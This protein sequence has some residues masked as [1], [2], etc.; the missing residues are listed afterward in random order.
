MTSLHPEIK[1]KAIQRSKIKFKHTDLSNEFIKQMVKLSLR[2]TARVISE[3]GSVPKDDQLFSNI[4]S[5]NKDELAAVD[6]EP[7]SASNVIKNKID[8]PSLPHVFGQITEIMSDL[9]SSASDFAEIIS[10]DPALSARMLKIVNSAFY[11]FRSRVDTISRAVAIIGTN[12][13][14]SLSLSMSVLKIF[15]N[16]PDHFVDMQ[17]FWQ[18]C[19]ACG[20]IAKIIATHQGFLNTERF[21]VAGLLHDIG[22][23]VLYKYLPNETKRALVQAGLN[24]DLLFKSESRVLG[25]NHSR[26]G[27]MLMKKW[28]LPPE[29]DH[30][31]RF[32]H[33]PE[34][35]SFF[36][37]TAIIHVS[38]ILTNAFDFGTSGERFVPPLSKEVWDVLKL[39][40]GLI[41]KIVDQTN[42]QIVEV[43]QILTS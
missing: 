12:D 36:H 30:M 11:G 22:R 14:Y 40:A 9:N 2:K 29:L 27:G 21:F 10:K 31:V 3:T 33:K 34:S 13:L 16:I 1:N 43:T 18:H 6:T 25:F 7:I 5:Y 4:T 37:E 17:S 8:L 42:D 23:L 39:P 19:I 20:I 41:E 38:D 26:I 24:G 35:S 15:D 32:H 28:H